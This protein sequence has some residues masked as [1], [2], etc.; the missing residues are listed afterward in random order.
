MEITAADI[1]AAIDVLRQAQ[2]ESDDI[3]FEVAV[4]LLAACRQLG[5]EAKVT[6]DLL[7]MEM[8]RQVEDA[9]KR[10]GTVNYMAVNDNTT[11]FDH[12]QIEAAVVAIAKEHLVDHET[13]EIDPVEVARQAAHW[14]RRV[15]VSP[16]SSAKIGVLG[17]LDVDV[18]TVRQRTKKGRKLYE[19]DT[20]AD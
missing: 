10:V 1:L 4:D 20:Q 9:P 13:G 6:A 7:Q 8:L 3:D 5:R 18:D 14:M 2:D 19:I 15:Y 11:T 12:D 16:S 17:E